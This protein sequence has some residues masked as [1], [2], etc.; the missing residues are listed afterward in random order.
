MLAVVFIYPFVW[1]RQRVVQ[2]AGEV[3]DNKL[4]PET[5][6]L[7]NYMEVWDEAPMALWLC[8]TC[9]VTV[10]AAVTVTISSSMV[11]WGFAYFRFPGRNA[12]FG[13]R[14]RDDDAARAP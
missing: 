6:T 7:E 4:I 3:F 11:A 12:L 14:A 2:A 10:L 8:N 13:A 9:I 1:L 5:F